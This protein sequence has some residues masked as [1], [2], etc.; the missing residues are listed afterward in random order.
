MKTF[1]PASFY[2]GG[3]SKALLFNRADLPEDRKLWDDIFCHVM[4]SPDAYGRQLD[5]MGG[6]LSSLSKVA[7]VAKSNQP[8]VDLDYTFVQIA[9]GQALADFGAMCGNIASAI[10]PFAVTSGIIEAADGPA[11]VTIRNTNTDKLF[12]AEF[13]MSDGQVVEQGDFVIAGVSGSAAPISLG[14]LDPAGATTGQLLPTGQAQNVLTLKSGEKVEASLID[15]TNPVVFVRASDLGKTGY[16]HPDQLEADVA[17][18]DKL[19]SI[20]CAGAVAMGLATTIDNVAPANPKIAMVAS[21]GTFTSLDGVTHS[22]EAINVSVRMLSMGRAHRA[23]T[24][25]AGMCL[26][27]ACNI[28]GSIAQHLSGQNSDIRIGHPS[29]ILPVSVDIEQ[30]VSPLVRSITCFRTQ[31]CL[32]TGKIPIPSELMEP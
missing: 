5:G 32:M 8:D 15:A 1:I 24:L 22:A 6:G 12:R 16:E 23:V 26:A 28:K 7:V 29:G 10:G 13:A 14:F 18:M 27:T 25:T 11:S 9:V 4:G 21:P 2:R 20:R 19:D 3:T 30:G 17:L 31:R